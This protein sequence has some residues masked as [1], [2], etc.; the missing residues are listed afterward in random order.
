MARR[1]AR[2]R[3]DRP[4]KRGQKKK[5]AQSVGDALAI[6]KSDLFYIADTLEGTRL[7]VYRVAE[8]RLGRKV[9]EEIF[10]LLRAEYKLFKCEN[11]NSWMHLEER[12]ENYADT[13]WC[14]ACDELINDDCGDLDD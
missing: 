9:G 11:C 10:D 1:A 8:M 7:N 4:R 6:S 5:P 13:D 12:S 3:K 14:N 2:A